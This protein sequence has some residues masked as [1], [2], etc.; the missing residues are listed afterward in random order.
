MQGWAPGIKLDESEYG[1]S[2]TP[3]YL[4]ICILCIGGQAYSTGCRS[5]L[6]SRHVSQPCFQCA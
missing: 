2:R 5:V 1:T 3:A 4:T 6:E